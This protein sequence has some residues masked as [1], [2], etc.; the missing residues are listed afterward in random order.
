MR[1]NLLV[2]GLLALVATGCCA[3]NNTERGAIDGGIIGGVLGTGI[4]IL[5]GA[6]AAGAA[7]GAGAGALAGGAIGNAQD[8]AEN[9]AVRQAVTNAYSNPPLALP[10]V[11]QL[12]QRGTPDDIIINQMNSTGSFYRLTAADIAYLRDHGVSDNVVRA[13]QSRVPQ[14]VIGRP[15][16]YGAVMV[17]EPPPPPVAVGVGFGFGGGRRCW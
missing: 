13:M 8:K 11:V 16:P 1:K 12:A 10:D 5:S 7:I 15:A 6:P 4:G 14:P 9:R 2:G 3:T 17:V